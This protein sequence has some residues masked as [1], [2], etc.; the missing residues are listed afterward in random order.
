MTTDAAPLSPKT[1]YL[2]GRLR[3]TAWA[4]RRIVY[5]LLALE[6]FLA[7]VRCGG[8]HSIW[9]QC[10]LVPLYRLEAI[11]IREELQTGI[12]LTED[13]A[14]RLV[15]LDYR[16]RRAQEEVERARE[17]ADEAEREQAAYHE[18]IRAGGLP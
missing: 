13:E 11:I 12:R 8:L 14:S 1:T 17:R 9:V 3:Q 6:N 4:D 2:A 10:H 15:R 5:H 16:R 18:W 7:G